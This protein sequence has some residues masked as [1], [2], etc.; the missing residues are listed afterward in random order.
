MHHDDELGH[1]DARK[2]QLG[3]PHRIENLLKSLALPRKPN[4]LHNLAVDDIY[5]RDVVRE[6]L[7]LDANE[8]GNHV[9]IHLAAVLNEELSQHVLEVRHSSHH[10]RLE[11]NHDLVSTFLARSCN[12]AD[13]DLIVKPAL[14][15]RH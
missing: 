12:V 9:L 7:V 14:H 5:K 10:L 2:G 3:L 1:L 8:G 6:L 4:S 11:T 13:F 15:P